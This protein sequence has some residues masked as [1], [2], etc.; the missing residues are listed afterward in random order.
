[1]YLVISKCLGSKPLLSVLFVSEQ[2]SGEQRSDVNEQK[3]DDQT[4]DECHI[5]K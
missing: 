5:C 3:S 2:I 4:S 1:M